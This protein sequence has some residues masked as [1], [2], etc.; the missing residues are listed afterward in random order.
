MV[1]D[2]ETKKVEKETLPQWGKIEIVVLH[3][4]G[5]K[6]V[7]RDRQQDQVKWM[8]ESARSGLV[9]PQLNPASKDF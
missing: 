2:G 9:G 8:V 7:K 3:I 4:S 6:R 1:W 5:S